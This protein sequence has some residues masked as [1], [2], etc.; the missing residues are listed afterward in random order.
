MRSLGPIIG[1]G[2]EDYV[3][4]GASSQNDALSRIL[5]FLTESNPTL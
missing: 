2:S 4:G 5:D 3:P 1:K